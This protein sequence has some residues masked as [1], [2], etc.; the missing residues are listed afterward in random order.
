MPVVFRLMIANAAYPRT[1][2]MA[3]HAKTSI[4]L[5]PAHHKMLRVQDG[6][7]ASASSKER[8]KR[9]CWVICAFQERSLLAELVSCFCVSYVV[10]YGQPLSVGV[11]A[12]EVQEHKSPQSQ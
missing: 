4:R 3:P 10:L 9:T 1:C 11:I 5:K 12:L 6:A 8:R 7:A 2:P